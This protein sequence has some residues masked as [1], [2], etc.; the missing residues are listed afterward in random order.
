[1]HQAGLL[2]QPACVGVVAAAEIGRAAILPDEGTANRLAVF[3][4]PEQ[5]CLTLVGQSDRRDVFRRHTCRGE[6]LR[7]DGAHALPDLLGIVFDPARP[8]VM[9]RQ[10]LGGAAGAAAAG[11][12]DDG[13]GTCCP[14]VDGE[15]VGGTHAFVPHPAFSPLWRSYS[16]S[17][18]ASRRAR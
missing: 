3:A 17:A 2:M 10:L 13:P 4:V 6:G 11:V 18:T 9:L 12:V 1:E 16:T 8:R 15:K 7:H 5:A 14:L